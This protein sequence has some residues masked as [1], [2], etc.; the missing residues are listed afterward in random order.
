[1]VRP[2]VDE[3]DA[4]LLRMFEAVYAHRHVTRAAAQLEI[5]QSTL[6]IGLGQLRQIFGDP[7]FVR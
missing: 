7:L 4:R 2:P 1:M 3:L 6:S 5:S